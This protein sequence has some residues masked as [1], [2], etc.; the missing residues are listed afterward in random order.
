[1]SA[2]SSRVIV[3]WVPDWPIVAARQNLQATDLDLTDELPLALIDRGTV[4]ACSSLARAAGV[5][6]GLAV[7]EAQLRCP[8]L[9]V[10]PYDAQADA[11]AFEHVVTLIEELVPGVRILRPGLCAIRARGPARFYGGEQ[12]AAATIRQAL[13]ESVASVLIGSVRVGIA[14]SPFGAEQ[15]A[16]RTEES[17]PVRIIDPGTTQ[18]FLAP[19]PISTLETSP[20]DDAALVP[21]LRRLGLHTLGDFAA[22]DRTAVGV[23]FAEAGLRAHARASATDR[24]SGAEHAPEADLGADVA[25]EPALDRVDQIAFGVRAAAESMIER[26]AHA[27][28]VCTALLITVTSESGDR[29]ERSWSHPHHFSAPDVVDRVRWQLQGSGGAA[30]GPSAPVERIEI[31]PSRVDASTNHEAGL[32]GTSLDERVHHA[33]ARLSSLLGHGAVS[34]PSLGGG[35][36]LAERRVLVPWGDESPKTQRALPWPG[37]IPPP[38]PATVFSAPRRAEVRGALGE[39]VDVDAR[40]TTNTAPVWMAFDQAPPLTISAWAGPWPVHQR[41]WDSD[42]RRSAARFQMID[43]TGMAWL[44]ILEDHT[45]AAEARYD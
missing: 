37:S 30:A 11:R 16:L 29:S 13:S 31:A 21:V 23:R 39:P 3:V 45:W 41:W 20:L 26:L 32:W 12:Q 4:F 35:R 8:E 22:L 33:L 6:R 36:F 24:L 28:L 17:A 1:M 34:T 15:A 9:L 43:S 40:G 42:T 10:A 7:R 19:L 38:A 2:S 18:G 5:R 14:D 27:G 25:F 44:L